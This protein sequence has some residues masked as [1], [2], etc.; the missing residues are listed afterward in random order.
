M[1]LPT[2]AQAPLRFLRDKHLFPDFFSTLKTPVNFL[3]IRHGQSEGNAAKIL[4]GRGEYPL[5]KEGRLQA[6][7][8]GIVLK[9]ELKDA[10]PGKTLFFSSPQSRAKETTEIIAEEILTTG[11]L[12]EKPVYLEDLMEMSL[13]IWAGKTWEEVKND[14]PSIWSGFMARSWDAVPEADSSIDLF[15]R[16]LRVWGALRDAAIDTGAENVI[17]VTHGG[18]IQWLLKSTFQCRAWFPLLPISNCGQF[19]LCVKPHPSEKSS[20][21]YW[22]EIDSHLPNQN[23]QP[24]GFPA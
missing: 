22:E 2:A 6:A 8:R 3:I 11:A 18:L 23:A 14:D 5:S 24:Q 1:I 12:C 4:Q 13:G 9:N 19:K 20:Y 16:S 10:K 7:A 17:V 15:E 21:M